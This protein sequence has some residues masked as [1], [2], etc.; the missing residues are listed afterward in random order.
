MGCHGNLGVTVNNTFAF[1]R[2]VPGADG[3]R[4]QDIRGIPDVP[5]RGHDTPE[6]LLYFERACGGDEFRANDEI[7]ERFYTAP[8]VPNVA[9]VLRAAPGGDRD[10]T[11]LVF[12][13]RE[14][15]LALTKAYMVLVR[16]QNFE[17][18]RDPIVRPVTNVFPAIE[19]EDAG[20]DANGK[21]FPDGRLWL[22]WNWQPGG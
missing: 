16:R 12:P 6:T 19:N 15:A 7:L 8:G 5:Q 2:K 1:A 4:H 10:L 22:D 21:V 17:Q 9:E 13:S 20:L 11:H 14:R 3:W 18:G